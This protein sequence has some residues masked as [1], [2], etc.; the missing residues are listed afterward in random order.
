KS[1]TLIAQRS[2]AE[3]LP[4]SPLTSD[5]FCSYRVPGCLVRTPWGC[6]GNATCAMQHS[7]NNPAGMFSH[8]RKGDLDR[9]IGEFS[10]AIELGPKS[11][12]RLQLPRHRLPKERQSRPCGTADANK[13][14]ALASQLNEA[15]RRALAKAPQP[16]GAS[17][18][19]PTLAAQLRAL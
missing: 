2:E 13:A 6:R 3:K 7:Q 16:A 9:A 14:I 10:K 12:Y 15:F 19:L 5:A 11:R 1:S 8:H 18:K 4:R 17:P